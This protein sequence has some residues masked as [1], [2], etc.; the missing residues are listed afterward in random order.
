MAKTQF[1]ATDIPHKVRL[2]DWHY[3][4]TLIEH[5]QRGYAQGCDYVTALALSRSGFR[6][7]LLSKTRMTGMSTAYFHQ[8]QHRKMSKQIEI[9]GFE[10][11]NSRYADAVRDL[12]GTPKKRGP[13]KRGPK[14]TESG[15]VVGL[16][17]DAPAA[18]PPVPKPEDYGWRPDRP[19]AN[20][21]RGSF[22]TKSQ[23][24][25][26]HDAF[27]R[28]VAAVYG[29]MLPPII[30]PR[31]NIPNRYDREALA[32]FYHGDQLGLANNHFDY[33]ASRGDS[34]KIAFAA[35]LQNVPTT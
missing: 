30:V 32:D 13:Y 9:N 26:Y 34:D 10:E 25:A 28:H 21:W 35:T 7:G 31:N 3:E 23:E 11:I 12:Y 29:Q 16:H 20:S 6:L 1:T 33:M 4:R 5:I 15:P 24:Q 22:E 19:G 17:E 27:D 8:T 18:I 2:R 14:S